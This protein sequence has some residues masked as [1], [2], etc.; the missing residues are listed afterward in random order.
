M[1]G[2]MGKP[3]GEICRQADGAIWVAAGKESVEVIAHGVDV[4][5]EFGKRA[6]LEEAL[7]GRQTGRKGQ[8]RVHSRCD[9]I[10]N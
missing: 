1:L 6:T 9:W 7:V 4:P 5:I 2:R 3:L 8:G 10:G